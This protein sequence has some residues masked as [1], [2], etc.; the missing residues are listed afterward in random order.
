M[1]TNEQEQLLLMAEKSDSELIKYAEDYCT[2]V[3]GR[4]VIRE[5]ARRYK[6]LLIELEEKVVRL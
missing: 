5:L 4:P 1:N 6:E 3:D 2:C